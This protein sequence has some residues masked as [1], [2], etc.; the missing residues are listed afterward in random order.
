MRWRKSRQGW[1]I[2]V[3]EIIR[4]PLVTL[5]AI[6]SVVSFSTDDARNFRFRVT[7]DDGNP[8]GRSCASQELEV[9]V[10]TSAPLYA[11]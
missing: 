11:L 3:L 8:L 5:L 2:R 4:N 9:S 10:L 7:I 1:P 6:L